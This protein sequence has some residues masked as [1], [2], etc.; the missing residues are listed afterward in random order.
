MRVFGELG[1]YNQAR[2]RA[3]VAAISLHHRSPRKP[4]R[5]LQT[6]INDTEHS[7]HIEFVLRHIFSK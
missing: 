7:T 1:R 2:F 4:L 6:R 3:R 5:D